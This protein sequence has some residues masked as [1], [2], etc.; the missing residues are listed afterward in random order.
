MNI[1]LF[2]FIKNIKTIAFRPLP[3]ALRLSFLAIILAFPLSGCDSG[4]V[5]SN[6]DSILT[7]EAIATAQKIFDNYSSRDF[8]STR[9]YVSP[10]FETFK[11]DTNFKKIKHTI[12]VH[13]VRIAD[14]NIRIVL[15][16][17]ADWTLDSDRTS[18]GGQCTM[19]FSIDSGKL[20]G[21]D[22]D[23]PFTVPR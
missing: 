19:T 21:L 13:R 15:G 9:S 14:Q 3:F 23:N 12:S 2:H 11:L 10:G 22:G 7:S 16:W 20:I 6:R 5:Q 1:D 18:S 17:E 8:D 4:E